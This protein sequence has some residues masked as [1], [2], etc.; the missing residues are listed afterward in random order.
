[1]EKIV[2]YSTGCPMCKMIEEKFAQKKVQ[3][4]KVSDSGIIVSKGITVVPQAEINGKLLRV[5]EILNWLKEA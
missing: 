4:V 3:Y 5:K 1:M 2:L